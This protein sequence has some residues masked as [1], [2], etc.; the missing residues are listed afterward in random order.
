MS[1]YKLTVIRGSDLTP[2]LAAR[3]SEIQASNQHL[4]SPYFAPEYVEQVASVRSDV[5]VAVLEGAQEVLGFLPFQCG[6]WGL[7]GPVGGRLSDFQ[8]MVTPSELTWNPRDLVRRCGLRA[9]RFTH[10][11]VAQEPF[12]PF[13]W[14]HALSPFVDLSGGFEAYR[15]HHKHCGSMAIEQIL[16]KLRKAG[17]R[18]GPV[19]FEL[20]TSDDSVFHTLLRWKSTQLRSTGQSDLFALPWVVELLDRLRQ[21][22]SPGL[23]GMLSALY[24]G[25]RLA[26]AHLGIRSPT[27]LH[28]WFPAYDPALAVHSPGQIS[29]VEVARGAAALGI[30]RLDLGKGA[31]SYKE[32]LMTGA[33]SVAD[34]AVDLRP[35]VAGLSQAW[36]QL[37]SWARRSALRRPL[38]RPARWLRRTIERSRQA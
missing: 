5:R 2:E 34:G 19:R 14:A 25:D 11:L 18:A 33:I 1:A 7:A 29:F 35:V 16:Y 31:E 22:R 9:W 23:A 27:V 30:E 8:A 32:R 28:W 36:F 6:Q 10:L 26:A 24:L 17:R 20:H 3:W 13:H 12:R 37:T 4:G 38:L 15:S 21:Y